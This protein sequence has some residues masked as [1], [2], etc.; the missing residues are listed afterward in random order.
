M[1]QP[2]GATQ[3]GATRT[4][5][6][7]TGGSLT[8]GRLLLALDGTLVTLVE[9]PDGLDQPVSTAALL[10]ADDLLLGVGRAARA[11]ELAL[12]VGVDSDQAIAWLATL[13]T[14][15]PA[16]ILV[17]LP[18]AD[19]V[20]RAAAGG[21]AVVAV[22]PHARWERIYN[23]IGRV[24]DQSRAGSPESMASGTAGDLFA[25]AQA[26]ADRTGG[27]VSIE[28][29]DS[30]VLAYSSSDEQADT[31]RRLSILGR[32]GPPEMLD[33]LRQWG[34]F[35]AL[36]SR[37]EVVSVGERA[38][39]GLRPR[40]AIGIREP[41]AATYLGTLWLQQG[42]TALSD[43]AGPVITGAAAV[44]ARIIARSA[45]VP[46]AHGEQVQRLLGL[47]GDVV[48]VPYLASALA[49]P[50]DGPV[51]VVGF[52]GQDVVDAGTVLT[53]AYLPALTLHASAFRP[54]SV[55]A[56]AG[57][58]VYVLFPRTDA[59][60][61]M[62]WAR[63][64]VAA[65]Q[66]QFGIRVRGVVADSPAGLGAVAGLRGDVDRVL[67]AALREGAHID[68]VSTVEQ[69]R[70]PVLLGEIVG[71][72]ADNP[73]L[74]DPRVAQLREYDLA[75]D[76]ALVPSV[77]AYLDAF[78]D[79]RAAAGNLHVHP[80]TLRYRLRRARELTGL[81]LGDQSTRLVVALAL[82]V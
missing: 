14:R 50:G 68:V 74:I 52:G 26:V 38:D 18:D 10:D 66:R 2:S 46:S 61:T 47:R 36:R 81:D 24:L 62:R 22:D 75:H 69:S 19:L 49:L 43:D 67:D 9:A 35:S 63:V 27:L 33:W 13:G 60:A 32:E 42:A 64:T 70:T 12:L 3:T 51:A 25:L 1:V 71:L 53:G 59:G 37:A 16:A 80:N 82:R 8:L 4:G 77:R 20:R 73:D 31:L 29:A 39:L 79:V 56:A 58:R 76:A 7:P 15:T 57:D 45:A 40:I 17:K 21:I 6:I 28:D 34:V 72:L 11:A 5:A 65:A 78:G 30:H 44:A 41:G 54:D 23:L 48:D 55:T